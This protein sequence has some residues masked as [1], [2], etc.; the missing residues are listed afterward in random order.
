MGASAIL[1]LKW[2]TPCTDVKS[3]A[4]VSNF[5]C[6]DWALGHLQFQILRTSPGL[7]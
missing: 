2:K 4:L 1:R 3:A 6:D 7:W 5:R